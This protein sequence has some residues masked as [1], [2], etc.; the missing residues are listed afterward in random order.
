L[1]LMLSTIELVA[2]TGGTSGPNRQCIAA[3][4]YVSMRGPAAWGLAQRPSRGPDIDRDSG[5]RAVEACHAP[6][7]KVIHCW[8]TETPVGH[9]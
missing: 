6:E 2:V 9:K 5:A 7:C 8:S 4:D 3:A 1:I